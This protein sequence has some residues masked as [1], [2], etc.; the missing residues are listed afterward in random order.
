MATIKT[1]INAAPHVVRL[2]EI[3]DPAAAARIK[4]GLANIFVLLIKA[5]AAGIDI[6]T[7]ED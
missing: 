2:A 1:L 4:D 7:L 3:H 6:D 5:E